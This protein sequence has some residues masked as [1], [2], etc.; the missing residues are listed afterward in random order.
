M[1]L[2]WWELAD[3]VGYAYK[4]TRSLHVITTFDV[5]LEYNKQWINCSCW[6]VI[7][8]AH[9]WHSSFWELQAHSS[10]KKLSRGVLCAAERT[11]HAVKKDTLSHNSLSG[12]Q[13]T[14]CLLLPH[15]WQRGRPE[16]GC[17]PNRYSGGLPEQ[18]FRLAVRN[19]LSTACLISF[20]E[21][22]WFAYG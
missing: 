7:P 19:H 14:V 16:A 22:Q 15:C 5:S 21:A 13:P 1:P 20:T 18:I 2:T 6:W 12:L 17:Q 11:R 10:L 9:S 4:H 3:V 8:T